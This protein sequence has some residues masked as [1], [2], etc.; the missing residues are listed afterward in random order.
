MI[1]FNNDIAFIVLLLLFA[2]APGL[3]SFRA[4]M[5]ITVLEDL[6]AQKF[7]RPGYGGK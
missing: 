1:W 2:L 4:S 7:H 3:R 5:T 6:L